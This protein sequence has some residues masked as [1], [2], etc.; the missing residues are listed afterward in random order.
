MCEISHTKPELKVADKDIVVYK[1][2]E[3]FTYKRILF[4]LFKK[5]FSCNSNIYQY[6]YIKDKVNTTILSKP[7][8]L[9]GIYYSEKGFYS[10]KYQHLGN[11]KFIIPKGAKYYEYLG[12][13]ISDKIIF[14][15]KL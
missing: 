3:D 13:Y 6:T 2:V 9:A 8:E 4:G 15:G 1:Y 11:V 10:Y 7:Y 12:V 14:K 5:L